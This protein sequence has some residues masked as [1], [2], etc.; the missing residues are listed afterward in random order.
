MLTP[1]LLGIEQP[2]GNLCGKLA[3]DPIW[4]LH[5]VAFVV[6]NRSMPLVA[7]RVARPHIGNRRLGECFADL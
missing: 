4:I 1:Y 6:A 2:G 7:V 5:A 3:I